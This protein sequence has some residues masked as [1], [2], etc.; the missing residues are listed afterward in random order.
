[1]KEI[2]LLRGSDDVIFPKQPRGSVCVA[3]HRQLVYLLFNKN[4]QT[5]VY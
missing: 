1:M 3:H 5:F 2:Q 4:K